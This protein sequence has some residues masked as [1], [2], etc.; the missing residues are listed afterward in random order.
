MIVLNQGINTISITNQS[1]TDN[2]LNLQF[3]SALLLNNKELDIMPHTSSD[4]FITIQ[5]ELV[6]KVDEDFA[7][8]KIHLI[9]GSHQINITQGDLTFTEI[10]FVEF[11]ALS[12]KKYNKDQ[13]IHIYK[14]NG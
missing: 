1:F 6:D 9:K 2:F 10:I 8:N 4:R 5:F 11:D 13:K 7:H 3:E 14:K 12:D